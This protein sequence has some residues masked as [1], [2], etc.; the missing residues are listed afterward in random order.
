MTYVYVKWPG[1]KFDIQKCFLFP[2]EDV[3][4]ESEACGVLELSC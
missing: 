2:L 3:C 4:N 1:A